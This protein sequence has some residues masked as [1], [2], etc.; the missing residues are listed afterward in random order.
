MENMGKS[1][2][3]LEKSVRWPS[4]H[5]AEFEVVYKKVNFFMHGDA[6]GEIPLLS[7]QNVRRK[8]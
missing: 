8:G 3:V 1:G 4:L 2:Q 7:E 6:Q 5:S